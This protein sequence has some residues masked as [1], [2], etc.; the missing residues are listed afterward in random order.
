MFWRATERRVLL[1]G[2]NYSGKTTLLYRWKLGKVVDSVPTIGFNIETIEHSSGHTFQVW[3]PGGNC[4]RRQ[5]DDD[6]D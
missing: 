6:L 5:L 3:E 2:V 1:M 4:A